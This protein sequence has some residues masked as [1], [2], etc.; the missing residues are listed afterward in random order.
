[1]ARYTG[2]VIRLH[3]A[4][5]MNLGLKGRR[6][7][8]D[9]YTK[10]LEK[11]PGQ[12]GAGRQRKQ[13]DYGVQFREKQKLK[14]IYGLLERQ[15]TKLMKEASRTKGQSG[16]TLLELLERRLDNVIYR[17]GLS[18]SRRAARQLVTHGHFM[19]NGARVD[20]G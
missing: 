6:D 20:A 19:L 9:K 12:H 13:S 14:R 11:K 4:E 18:V 15:F 8:D 10:R 2:P 7:T 3:R 1:M 5:G 17:A 16:A